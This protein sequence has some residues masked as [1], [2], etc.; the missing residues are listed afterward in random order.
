M[1]TLTR[2]V[3]LNTTLQI[4][5]KV[6]TT[7]IGIL[8]FGLLTRFLGVAGYGDYTTVF[9]YNSLLVILAD[10]GFSLITLKEISIHTGA[11]R[12]Q[13]FQNALTLRLGF[14][15]IVLAAMLVFLPF[16]AYPLTLKIGIAL[17][18]LSLLWQTQYGTVLSYLQAEYRMY[19]AV[20]ADIIGRLA[21]LAGLFW[22]L[23]NGLGIVPVFGVTIVGYLITF[24]C[25]LIA[26]RADRVYGFRF[27][28]E[29]VWRITRE[30]VWMGVVIV[31]S[32]LYFKID[33]IIL[34]LMKSSVDV[35]IYGAPFKVLEILL[36]IPQMFLGNVF[37]ALSETAQR[38][39]AKFARLIT[40]SITGLAALALPLV[41]GGFI[42][43]TPIIKAAAGASYA[44]TTTI[45]LFG[46]PITAAIV[47]Q[48]LLIALFLSFFVALFNVSLVAS[49]RQRGLILP[50]ILATLVN[51]I[52]NVLLIPRFSYLATAVNS[53][54]AEVV[55]FV[56]T[57]FLIKQ[58]SALRVDWVAL[59]NMVLSV[60][61]MGIV[62]YLLRD[63]NLL[64]AI[65]AGALVYGL[66]FVRV[67]KVIT[68]R[69]VFR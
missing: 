32:F 4:A 63:A 13:V 19:Q 53:V 14:G 33:T 65:T 48:L 7:V 42:L 20:A 62:V 43:A 36:A 69:D 38:D 51:I 67:F 17:I 27:D 47:M 58:T 49:G 52:A 24:I 8:T 12:K 3:V 29:I 1:K 9:A 55:I 25:S 46:Q 35:G 18:A 45:S 15:V 34:S 56:Y 68:L 16:L 54:I 22:V 64:L 44:S 21:I 5:G 28:K 37:P 23:Q 30:S 10:F 61:G 31:F 60:L 39:T 6:V 57:A 66:L 26:I 40:K 59:R 11:A 41:V 50:Y 2:S